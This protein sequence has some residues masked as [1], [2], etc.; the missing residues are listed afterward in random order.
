MAMSLTSE[1][2]KKTPHD[3]AYMAGFQWFEFELKNG[4]YYGWMDLIRND[5]GRGDTS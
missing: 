4:E 2:P 5:F 1:S 3:I